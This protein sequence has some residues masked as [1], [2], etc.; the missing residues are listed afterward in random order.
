MKSNLS[1]SES[2]SG[3]PEVPQGA[4]LAYQVARGGLFALLAQYWTVAVGFAA[5]I[6]LARILT[7]EAF[8][9]FALAMF[10]AQILRVQPKLSIG[11]AFMQRKETTP[12]LLGTFLLLELG[13]S[14]VGVVLAF[15]AVPVLLQ[16]GYSPH[17]VEVSVALA[18][19]LLFESL[20]STGATLL[21]KDLQFGHVSLVQSVAFPLSYA[22]AFWMALND[23]GVWSLVVQSLTNNV[24][25]L[26]GIWLAV[27]K[28]H[29]RLWR[30]AGHFD[31]TTAR[32]FVRFGCT[33][34]LGLLGGLL[35]TQLDNFLIGTFVNL[36]VLGFYDR[37][38]RTAQW[39]VLLLST[40]MSRVV[41][42]S[43]AKLQDDKVRLQNALTMVLW[44]I[45]L[46]A[47]PVT[48][49][50]FIAAPDLLVL[51]YGERWLP[52][53]PYLRL[54]VL[55][56]VAFPLL[57]NAGTLFLALGKPYL[58]A[59]LSVLQVLTLGAV[60]V[61]LTLRWGAIGTCVAVGL[62]LA[63]GIAVIYYHA[64]REVS[65][66]LGALL[67]APVLAGATVVLGYIAA[68]YAMD[69]EQF[70]ILPVRVVVKSTYAM[71]G[72]YVLTFLIEKEAMRQR[73]AHIWRL[74]RQ[75]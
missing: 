25:C 74:L 22:P 35:L 52:S 53:V 33:V 50:V 32:E 69:L 40:L 45:I 58:P 10:F 12:N 14:F 16:L 11:H 13:A 31:A 15:G 42:V 34:G 1:E 46:V 21:D 54:L 6:V 19:V 44:I 49:A 18:V 8:G 75:S 72:F 24:L 39:P 20:T 41:L 51:L 37:A 7:P 71:V 30:A 4:T 55:F 62:S 17:V 61:L 63:L 5:G 56:S 26:L 27:A 3:Q 64:A 59:R 57:S 66:E 23:W 43:Y 36:T 47:F 28:R 38:Y 48:L 9:T 60:G 68:G 70:A 29:P 73:L 2:S 65:L 67:K